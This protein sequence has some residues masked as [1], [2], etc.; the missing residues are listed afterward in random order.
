M[1]TKKTWM[2]KFITGDG[3]KGIRRSSWGLGTCN[4]SICAVMFGMKCWRI[5]EFYFILLV[6]PPSAYGILVP[7]PGIKLVPTAL[8]AESYP[9]DLQASS[10]RILNLNLNFQII[11]K[12]CFICQSRRAEH[13]LWN[14]VSLT[15]KS[16]AI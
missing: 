1:I 12:I 10:L 11:T 2:R 5:Q 9:L 4:W 7:H 15:W 6:V 13:I 16:P 3:R 8:E 14:T